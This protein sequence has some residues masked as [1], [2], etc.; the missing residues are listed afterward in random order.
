MLRF[1]SFRFNLYPY[2]TP[3]PSML[4]LTDET[5]AHLKSWLRSDTLLVA[6]LCAAW[7]D[8]CS[9]YRATFAML[10]AQH[11]EVNFVWID[12]E[13]HADLIGDI[14]VDNFPTLL[15]QRG[16]HVT[17]FGSV[18][19]GLQVA[20]RLIQAQLDQ[21]LKELATEAT[22]SEERQRW[23]STMHLARRLDID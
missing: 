11:A 17:F 6:C 14:D 10:A 7:C 21:S 1:V 22:S 16:P 4:T 3:L 9:Q 23:Q 15:M 19:P 8:V 20:H 12:I 5:R 13:E 2:L 18:P